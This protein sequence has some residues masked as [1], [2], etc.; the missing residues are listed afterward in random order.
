MLFVLGLLMI[1]SYKYQ[2]AMHQHNANMDR[3]EEIDCHHFHERLLLKNGGKQASADAE[4]QRQ[5][6]DAWSDYYENK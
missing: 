2:L 6:Y 4:M 3:F 5:A 1:V